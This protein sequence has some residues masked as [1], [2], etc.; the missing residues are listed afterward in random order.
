MTRGIAM[1]GRVVAVFGLAALAGCTPADCDP[2]HAE[3]F[4]GIGC[5]TSGSYAARTVGLQNGLRAAEANQLEQ[6]A[7]ASRA[8]ADEINAEHDL[9]RRRSELAMLDG[10]LAALRRQVDAA[11]Q[12]QG[13]DQDALNRA[14]ASLAALQDRR[15]H[16]PAQPGDSDLGAL[17]GQTRALDET[18]RRSGL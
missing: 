9:N 12:R 10:R 15:A 17:E 11:R 14:Q 3:L 13:V 18:L 4:A 6:Q 16:M 2:T 1:A 7:R 8:A 5:A